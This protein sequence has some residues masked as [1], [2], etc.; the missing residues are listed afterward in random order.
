MR[1]FADSSPSPAL[2]SRF[3]CLVSTLSELSEEELR[4]DLKGKADVAVSFESLLFMLLVVLV[5]VELEAPLVL[6]NGIHS[7]LKNWNIMRK[8]V[9]S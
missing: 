3:A 7:L 4:D 9:D 1:F 5:V 8:G 2:F 6:P